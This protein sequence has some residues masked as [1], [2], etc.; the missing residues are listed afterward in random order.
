[1]KKILITV[2]ALILIAA[3]PSCG[4]PSEEPTSQVVIFQDNVLEEKIREAMDRPEGDITIAEAEAVTSFDFE[5][6]GS[7]WS[8]PRIE[9]ISDLKQFKNL[10][11]LNLNWALYDSDNDFDLSP[12]SG[13][14]NLERLYICCDSISDISALSKLTNLADLWIWGNGNIKDIS[15]LSN[16][17]KM[18]SLWIKTNSISDISPLSNMKKLEYLYMENNQVT[19]LSPLSGL[20]NLH[21]ILLSGNPVTDYSPLDS[22]YQNLEEKDF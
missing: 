22:I 7:D 8:L 21:Y 19:D 4:G 2:M 13:L 15:A 12:L 9:N 14:T 17:T 5:M 3:F 1:M 10:T 20:T 6:D 11:G 18:E 16:M